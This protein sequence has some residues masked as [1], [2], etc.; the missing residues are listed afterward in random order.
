M[1]AA[2]EMDG[3]DFPGLNSVQIVIMLLAFGVAGNFQ[4]S[5][6]H[7]APRSFRI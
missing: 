3:D 4:P 6:Y 2:I 7:D 5:V 1:N